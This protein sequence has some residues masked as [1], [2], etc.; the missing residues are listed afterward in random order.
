M[1]FVITNLRDAASGIAGLRR[2]H[3]DQDT[4]SRTLLPTTHGR[5]SRR[6]G[7]QVPRIWSA[8]H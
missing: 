2:H 7:G 8:G 6:S 1:A 5:R 4:S 3:N